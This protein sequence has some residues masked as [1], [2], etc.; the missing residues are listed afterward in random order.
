MGKIRGKFPVC[1]G[2]GSK[3]FKMP[4]VVETPLLRNCSKLKMEVIKSAMN[5][6]QQMFY[7]T[8]TA[9]NIFAL[10]AA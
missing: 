3:N 8:V 5:Q 10:F 4:R 9:S 2:I 1:W 6:K 7:S